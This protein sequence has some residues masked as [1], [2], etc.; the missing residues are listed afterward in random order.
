MD[1]RQNAATKDVPIMSSKEDCVSNMEQR[2]R[3]ANMTDV[4]ITSREEEYVED[5]VQK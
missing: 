2:K 4:P 3:L 1:Q 5:M